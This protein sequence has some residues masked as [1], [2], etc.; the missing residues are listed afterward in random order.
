MVILS[1]NDWVYS[2]A[3]FIVLMRHPAQGATGVWVILGLVFSGFLCMTS[4]YLILPR[5]S[6]LVV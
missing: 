6:S 1:A 3:L 5:V 4:H 2:F